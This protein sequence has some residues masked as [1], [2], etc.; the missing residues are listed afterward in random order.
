MGGMGFSLTTPVSFLTSFNADP[1]ADTKGGNFGYFNAKESGWLLWSY[2]PD[3]DEGTGNG[4]IQSKI[5]GLYMGQSVYDPYQ[6]NP[7]L[8]L[9]TGTSDAP[10]LGMAYNYDTTNGT[11]SKGDVWRVKQ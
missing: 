4:E 11:T 9:M 10:C 1:F 2:G 8:T 7:T 6:S 3:T 5:W